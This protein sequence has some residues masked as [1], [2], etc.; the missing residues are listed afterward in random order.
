MAAVCGIT[1]VKKFT[2]RADPN[3]EYANTYHFSGSVPSDNT[4]WTA[5]FDALVAQEKTVYPS[6]TLVVQGYGYATDN[7]AD[8]SVWS[9]DV[10]SSPVAGTL[11][12]TSG[13]KSMGDSAVWVRW[14]TSRLNSKG[15]PI[16]LRKYFHPACQLDSTH[17]DDIQAAQSAALLAF[18]TKLMDGSFID[19]RT[20]RSQ[21]NAETI[22]SR[23]ASTVLTTRTL[24][25]RGKRP[26]S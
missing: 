13:L 11:S 6:T 9:H 17:P 26:G 12:M 18:G 20:I 25:R 22:I 23:S 8:N 2:Y 24:K 5:L 10:H 1:L 7:P 14:K 15:K 3:E 21:A 16:Y 19:G 4:A